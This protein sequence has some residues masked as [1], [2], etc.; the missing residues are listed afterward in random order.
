M[1]LALAMVVGR[2]SVQEDGTVLPTRGA[3][4]AAR[5]DEEDSLVVALS[6]LQCSHGV[7]RRSAAFA[8]TKLFKCLIFSLTRQTLD[9]LLCEVDK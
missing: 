8:M 6:G 7:A 1:P 4:S 3:Q 5:V 2:N 9:G